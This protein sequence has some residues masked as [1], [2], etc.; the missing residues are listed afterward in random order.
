MAGCVKLWYDHHRMRKFVKNPQGRTELNR[1][2]SIIRSLSR[3]SAKTPMIEKKPRVVNDGVEVP[4]GIRAIESGIEVDGVWISRSNT[5]VQL[6][7][8]NS[9]GNFIYGGFPN[10][11]STDFTSARTDPMMTPSP[12]SRPHSRVLDRSFSSDNML[13]DPASADL[14][15]EVG[16]VRYPPHSYMRYENTKHFRKSRALSS[17]DN[18]SRP[19]SGYGMCKQSLA[20]RSY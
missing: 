5:P 20:W 18:L 16:A 6:P 12:A 17:S 1:E 13:S 19:V 14:M 11:S 3:R 9:S 10:N 15:T 8:R 7:S 2:K 4:F